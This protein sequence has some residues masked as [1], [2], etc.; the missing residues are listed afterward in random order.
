[1]NTPTTNRKKLVYG[2]QKELDSH[3]AR[4]VKSGWKVIT[5]QI[6]YKA[7][8]KKVHIAELIKE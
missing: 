2:G 8:G 7:R 1:M 6:C 5:P 3:I 4:L